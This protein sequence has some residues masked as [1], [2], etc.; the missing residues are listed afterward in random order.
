[1]KQAPEKTDT[2]AM[3]SVLSGKSPKGT[4][5]PQTSRITISPA[6]N[7]YVV[8]NDHDTGKGDYV[9]PTKSVYS[10]IAG[11][12]GH[13]DK[14]LQPKGKKKVIDTGKAKTKKVRIVDTAKP[15]K[16]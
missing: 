6:S 14:H 1:M 10:D 4:G 7:G 15:R 9:P 5:S 13:L 3:E 2:K 16:A 12:H 11:V 8:D